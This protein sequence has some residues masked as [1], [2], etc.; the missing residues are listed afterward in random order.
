MTYTVAATYDNADNSVGTALAVTSVVNSAGDRNIVFVTY[1]SGSRTVESISHNSNTYNYIGTLSDATNGQSWAILECR[2]TSASAGSTLTFN[3]ASGEPSRGVAVVRLTGLD[4]AVACLIAQNNPSNPGT[5][6]NA[7][8]STNLTPG[9]QPGVLCGFVMD[10]S[11]GEAGIA[12][13]TGFTDLGTISTWEAQ[14]GIKAHWEHKAITSTSAV[15]ATFTATTGTGRF[16]VMAAYAQE[17]ASTDTLMGQ[18][19]L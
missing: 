9:A 18:A 16:G 7:V 11:G 2:N 13:G 4:T 10:D 14:I 19:C 5:G 8:T 6:A 12:S 17:T 1:S 15:A 3:L